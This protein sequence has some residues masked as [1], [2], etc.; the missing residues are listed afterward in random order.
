VDSGEV[1]YYFNGVPVE[2]PHGGEYYPE[3]NMSINFNHWIASNGYGI[4]GDTRTYIFKVDW[5]LHIKDK[6]LSTIEVESLVE[7]YRS[8]GDYRDSFQ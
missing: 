6:V 2:E 3:S 7:E 1:K 8:R 4:S 5:V